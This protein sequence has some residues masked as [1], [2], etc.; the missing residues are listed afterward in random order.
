MNNCVHRSMLFPLLFPN[1]G[2]GWR[3]MKS[4]LQKTTTTSQYYVYKLA[5][6]NYF[7]KLL[8]SCNIAVPLSAVHNQC[9]L[10]N[11]GILIVL[12]LT[13]PSQSLQSTLTRLN[14]HMQNSRLNTS[15]KVKLG[16]SVILLSLMEAVLAQGPQTRCNGY[17][18]KHQQ[19]RFLYKWPDQMTC[20]P[21]WPE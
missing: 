8:C 2:T 3:F 19:T 18:K 17:L 16:R 9:L 12:Y 21:K 4:Q 14:N 5:I 20:S 11:W 1:E 6:K 13:E 10:E 7:N 15:N